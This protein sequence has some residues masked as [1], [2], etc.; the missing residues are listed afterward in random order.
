MYY[1]HG[2]ESM[3]FVTPHAPKVKIMD[4]GGAGVHSR[5]GKIRR[6]PARKS[7]VGG[8]RE[9]LTRS[10]RNQ[11]LQRQL[12]RE[13]QNSGAELGLLTGDEK[14][15]RAV[16]RNASSSERLDKPN[17]DEVSLGEEKKKT[18]KKNRTRLSVFGRRLFS[19]GSAGKYEA[20]V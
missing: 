4:D 16:M 6:R 10:T 3:S 15:S 9:T 19:A 11:K 2:E 8:V 18:T 14:K 1:V 12:S 20:L 5:D 13:A 7:T 17:F